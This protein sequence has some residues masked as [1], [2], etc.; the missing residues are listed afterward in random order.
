VPSETPIL[1]P[2]FRLDVLNEQLWRDN[3][4]VPVR[5]KPFAVLTYLATHAGRLVPRAELVKAVWPDTYVSEGL[6]CVYIREVRVVLGDDS[7]VPR[8]IETVPRRGYRFI[9]T[10][11]SESVTL[12]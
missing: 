10:P 8:F 3:E 11:L 1:F 12:R 4:L 5:P 2:P 7:E 6:L 9:S